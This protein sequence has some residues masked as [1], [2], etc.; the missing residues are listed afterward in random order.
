MEESRR[1]QQD[2][3][4]WHRKPRPLTL[5]AQ[6]AGRVEGKRKDEPIGLH[7]QD[8][9]TPPPPT[10]P[11]DDSRIL[12]SGAITTNCSERNTPPLSVK[13]KPRPRPWPALSHVAP[14]CWGRKP[15]LASSQAFRRRPHQDLFPWPFLSIKEQRAMLVMGL[16]FVPLRL[17]LFAG[18]DFKT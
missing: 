3:E 17:E 14:G 10:Q 2:P 5:H 16:R 18:A 8:P 6:C 7:F 15:E 9:G 12:G 13:P 1:R 4:T 11:L